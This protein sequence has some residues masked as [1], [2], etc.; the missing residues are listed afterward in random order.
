MRI[1]GVTAQLEKFGGG[2]L[3]AIVGFAEQGAQGLGTSIGGVAV[4]HTQA[5]AVVGHDGQEVGARL[6]LGVGRVQ[7]AEQQKRHAKEFQPDA[8]RPQTRLR[9]TRAVAPHQYRRDGCE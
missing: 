4:A 3:P 2:F 6:W 7:E 5:A 9:H 8:C 1:K